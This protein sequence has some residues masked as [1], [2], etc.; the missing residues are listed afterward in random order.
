MEDR[1][2]IC[3]RCGKILKESGTSQNGKYKKCNNCKTITPSNG[4]ET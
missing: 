3:D 4:K 2:S 1:I